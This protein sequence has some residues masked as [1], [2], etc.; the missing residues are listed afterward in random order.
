MEHLADRLSALLD[1]ELAPDEAAAA[2][3]HLAGCQ[4]CA[5]EL[6]AVDA[7]R[8]VLRGL[9]QVA[10]PAG[11]LE[12][13]VRPPAPVIPLHRRSAVVSAVASVAASLLLLAFGS[14]IGEIR[15]PF[16]P[17]VS[18]AVQDHTSAVAALADAGQLTGASLRE[19]E[20]TPSTD[21]PRTLE[22]LPAPYRAPLELDGGYHLV[23]AFGRGDT[24]HLVYER[25]DHALS[26]FESVGDVQWDRLPSDGERHDQD[27]VSLW[28]G[29]EPVAGGWVVVLQ[30]D[31][32]TATVVGDE[33][34]DEVLEAA[35]SLPAPRSLSL[36]Q[37][38]RDACADSLD[39]LSPLG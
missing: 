34:A 29:E 4:P 5:T 36:L 18:G 32:L 37:R 2:R 7:A 21:V 33:G 23:Q 31:G 17:E 38:V 19:D 15:S 16:A 27:G 25:G 30:H 11:F 8:S 12:G 10:P 3:A 1:G 35:R 13:L 24:V 20:T 9:P 14:G 22:D 28:Q 26:V 39:A 6:E